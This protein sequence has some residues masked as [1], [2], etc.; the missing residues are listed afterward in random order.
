MTDQMHTYCFCEKCG[1]TIR[2]SRHSETDCE[3]IRKLRKAI[4]KAPHARFCQIG[5]YTEE[6]KCTCW[7]SKALGE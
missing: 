7:K 3:T 5:S 2:A 1:A 4:E 6:R